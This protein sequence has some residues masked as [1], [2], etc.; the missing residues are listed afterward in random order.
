MLNAWRA[1][2]L[3]RWN[4]IVAEYWRLIKNSTGLILFAMLEARGA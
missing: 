3:E 1:I 2:K 4:M